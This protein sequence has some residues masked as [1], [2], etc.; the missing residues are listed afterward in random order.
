M[1]QRLA[2][3]SEQ[4]AAARDGAAVVGDEWWGE[5]TRIAPARPLHVV[6]DGRVGEQHGWPPPPE[7]TAP[8]APA[9]PVAPGLVPEPGRH[10]DRRS[11]VWAALLPETVRGRVA[12]TPGPVAVVAV[13]VALG[14]AWTCWQVVRDDPAAP[15]AVEPAAAVAAAQVEDLVPVGAVP[16]PAPD[17]A[18]GSTSA[19]TSGTVTVDVAGRVRRPGIVVLDA[20]ARVVDALERAGGARPSVDLTSLN[21]ARPLVDGEQILVGVPGGAG[22]GVVGALPPVAGAPGAAPVALVDLNLADQAQLET[23]PDVGP[24]TAAA[25]IGWRAEHGGFSAVTE[26]LEVDGIGEATLETLTPLVTV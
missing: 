20:G 11:V 25:I 3:L 13:L 14:L 6:P 8:T 15:T 16:A 1:S 18:L 12:L 17:P 19:A 2:L 5:H 22:G 21:L 9:V 4:L 7:P 24:V 10:A 23:L 26:L